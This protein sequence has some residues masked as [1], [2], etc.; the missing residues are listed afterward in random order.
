M[1]EFPYRGSCR[2]LRKP[3]ALPLEA[4]EVEVIYPG[5]LNPA[6]SQVSV[7]V[8]PGQRVG[9]LG[10]NGSGKSTFLR[11]AAGLL[12]LRAGRLLLFGQRP[13]ACQH[14]V[15]YL[16]QR[17]NLDWDFPITVQRFILTGTYVHLGWLRRP[18][19]KDK[20]AVNNVIKLLGLEKVANNQI[21]QL[22][23]GQQ[24]R[25]LIARTLMHDADLFLMDE[26][27]NAVDTET[28]EIIVFVLESLRKAGRTVLMSTHDISMSKGYFDF[29]I[30]L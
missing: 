29:C 6:F 20:E 25:A 12:P 28:Q 1:L 5:Q 13:G 11:A 27:L 7:S 18:R 4:K 30:K 22:S 8:Q 26:P 19:P 15:V 21:G 23:G 2:H 9:L 3:G 14:Q 10:P 16:P 24:Q 17:S